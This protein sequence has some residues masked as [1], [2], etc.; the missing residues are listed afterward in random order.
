MFEPCEKSRREGERQASLLW[1]DESRLIK[2]PGLIS[3][4]PPQIY[5]SERYRQ[6]FSGTS[7]KEKGTPIIYA[8]REN[9][10]I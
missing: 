2:N 6:T 10:I 7:A 5:S 8:H 1:T 9:V 4:W 3:R